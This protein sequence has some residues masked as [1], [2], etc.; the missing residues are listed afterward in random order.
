MNFNVGKYLAIIFLWFYVGSVVC[1][2]VLAFGNT[3]GER[4]NSIL[5][6]LCFCY[7][8]GV[9]DV[10]CNLLA[11]HTVNSIVHN[12]KT[13]FTIALVFTNTK[14]RD[15][16]VSMVSTYLLYFIGAFMY[17]EPSFMFTSFAQYVLLSPTYINVLNIYAF[18]NIHDV[19]WGQKGLNKPKIWGQQNLSVRILMNW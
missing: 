14:F 7:F 15:L 13:D 2:F 16:V 10:C 1:T 19:S 9:Y 12:H 17:G 11:V 5:L 6:L 3:L 4:G 8:N 18:C